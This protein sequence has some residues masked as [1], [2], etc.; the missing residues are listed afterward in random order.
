MTTNS[1]SAGTCAF[2]PPNR[3]VAGKASEPAKSRAAKTKSHRRRISRRCSSTRMFQQM[4]SGVGG[5]GPFS[6]G[7]GVKPWRSFLTDEYSN[8]SPRWRHRYRN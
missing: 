3:C 4:F 5:E 8:P 2:R 7:N 6:G 1:L